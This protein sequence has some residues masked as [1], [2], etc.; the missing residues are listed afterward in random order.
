MV[1]PNCN[2]DI[3]VQET[4]NQEKYTYRQ[5]KCNLCGFKFYTK[6]SVCE[7]SEAA[8]LFREWIKERGR[9][10][11]A[12]QKGLDYEV[13]FA[14]GREKKAEPKLPTSPLF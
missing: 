1:C 10:H 11:R 12:K 5:K 3:S 4:I 6:E 2:G 7:E 9:K 14:D 8:P 13:S